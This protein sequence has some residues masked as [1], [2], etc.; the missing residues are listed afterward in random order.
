[1][2]IIGI[3]DLVADIY[4]DKNKKLIGVDGGI[5]V[6]N[7]L[8]NLSYFG[9]NTYS[10]SSVSNDELGKICIKSLK[11]C[12][13]NT[14]FITKNNSKTKSY[15][16]YNILKDNKYIFK[17]TTICPYCN[18]DNW[19]SESFID[20]DYILKNLYKDDILI[21]DNLNNKNQFIIDNTKNIKL[22]DLGLINEFESLNNN[23][24][25]RT[26]LKTDLR[27][28]LSIESPE[29]LHNIAKNFIT[30]INFFELSQAPPAFDIKIA[31]KKPLAVAPASK[32]TTP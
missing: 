21:F 17:S 29:Q 12:N 20:T 11:D 19:Y 2:R 27:T 16:I 22:L 3:G 31:I 8:C 15:Y 18:K 32:P 7:I 5:S 25:V 23:E 6:Q 30:S 10:F 13:V 9:L 28:E 4:Y 1:M 24:I 14:S 26:R